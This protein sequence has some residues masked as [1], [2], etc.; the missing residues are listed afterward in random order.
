MLQ[1]LKN[2]LILQLIE[3]EKV[4]ESGIVLAAADREEAN[5]GL[6]I[7][8]GEGVEDIQAN[9]TVLPDWNKAKKTRYEDQDYYIIHQDDIVAI[10]DN[11][12]L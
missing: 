5:K 6:V 10:F 11:A 12:T 2:K 3:K 9:D 4:T 8:I 7:V 1:P